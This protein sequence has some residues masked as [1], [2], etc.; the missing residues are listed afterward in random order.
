MSVRTKNEPPRTAI[1][2]IASAENW[3]ESLAVEQL[4][5]TAK[6]P[7]IVS[8]VGFPDLHPGPG[9]PVGAAFVSDGVMYPHLA[10][11]DIGCGMA[12][13]RVGLPARRP[14]LDRWVKKLKGLEYPWDGDAVG[15]LEAAGVAVAVPEALGTIGGGN[16]FAEL[17]AV[18]VV[19]DL[20]DFA[21]LNLDVDELCVLV[22]SGSRGLGDTVLRGVT[23]RQERGGLLAGSEDASAYVRRHDH[24]V[25]WA[26]ENRRLIADRFLELLGGQA[27]TVSDNCHNSV[28]PAPWVG[29]NTWL[30]RKGA[31]ADC[32]PV[33]IPGSRGALSYLVV[34]QGDLDGAARSLA[35]GAGRKWARSDAKER[36]RDRYRPEKLERTDLGG[37]VICRDSELIYEEA[38]QAYKD[39]GRVVQDLVDAGLVRVIATL[40]PLITYKTKGNE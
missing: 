40:R 14:N 6:L 5:A 9:V 37:R 18:D 25:R 11:N 16:H 32:G 17:Q 34:P 24:A 3:V 39:I 35:H 31:A 21:A 13:W 27:V 33:V 12:L 38:P 26:S 8:A 20:A 19:H 29:A 1:R 10:G 30:H 28:T 22:H 15:R 4:T 23:Q 7:G 36:L 2:V